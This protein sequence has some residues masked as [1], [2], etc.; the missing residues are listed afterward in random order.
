V[1]D[2]GVP[3]EVIH[4]EVLPARAYWHRPI[5]KGSVLH[6]VDLEGSQAVDTDGILHNGHQRLGQVVVEHTALGEIHAARELDG[7]GGVVPDG[8]VGRVVDDR[9]LVAPPSPAP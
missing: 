3:G 5:A 9:T 8:R 7:I 1:S 2:P 4:D 6:I